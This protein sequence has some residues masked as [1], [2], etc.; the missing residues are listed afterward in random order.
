KTHL[1]HR[2]DFQ[3]PTQEV[4]PAALTVV[5]PEDQ[6]VMFP[7]DN[8]ELPTTGRRLAYAR[9]LTSGEHPLVSRVLVNRIWLH[10]FGRGLVET[11]ADFGKLGVAPSHPELLD[12]LAA[13]FVDQDWSLKS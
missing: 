9:W 2:G 11:P 12:W 3:Q 7:V 13:E 8:A 1:F 5:C 4:L 10:H 6:Q